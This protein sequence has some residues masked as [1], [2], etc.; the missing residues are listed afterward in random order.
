[1]ESLRPIFAGNTINISEFEKNLMVV[2]KHA[3]GFPVAVLNRNMPEFYCIPEE[4]Y[5]ELFHKLED[6]ELAQIVKKRI[7]Q[8]EA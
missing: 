6:I 7:G 8:E 4:A 5:A 3:D 2:F 1:M